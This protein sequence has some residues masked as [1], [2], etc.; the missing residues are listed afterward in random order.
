MHLLIP[1]QMILPGAII[2]P[3]PPCPYYILSPR[4][5]VLSLCLIFARLIGKQCYLAVLIHRS[6]IISE[7]E[8]FLDTIDRVFPSHYSGHSSPAEASR[9]CWGG[10]GA[11]L[12]QVTNSLTHV[13]EKHGSRKATFGLFGFKGCF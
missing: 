12:L 13:I 2:K 5:R 6:L 7:V 10:R 4:H 11:F 3:C 1:L 8:H 9:I